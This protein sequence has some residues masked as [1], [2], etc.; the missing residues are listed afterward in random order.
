V[1]GEGAAGPLRIREAVPGDAVLVLGFIEALADYERLRHECVATVDEI[2]R[3][4]FGPDPVPRVLIAEWEGEP[5]GFALW[6]RN[7]STFLA[8]PGIW[9]EDL[10]VKPDAR[11]RGIGK[12]LLVAL[13]R[14]AAERG[15]GRVEWWVLDWNAPS[16][17][18]YQSLGA[19]AMDEWTVFRLTGEAMHRLAGAGPAGD[20]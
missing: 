20:A 6:F 12:A 7:F 9:L 2:D 5:V 18:F 4:L 1:S 19:V 10:F 16:I 3:A 14:I 8:R 17:A 15:Y 13:T 11:G